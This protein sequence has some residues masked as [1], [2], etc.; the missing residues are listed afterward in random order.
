MHDTDDA[1]D[2]AVWERLKKISAGRCARLSYL[3]HDGKR[4]YKEDI[5]LHDRL[6]ASGHMS[7]TE[8]LARP[9]TRDEFDHFGRYHLHLEPDGEGV[10][11]I[12]LT[13][14]EYS[15]V[16]A[17]KAFDIANSRYNGRAI[18]KT[19]FDAFCGNFNGWIQ[20]RKTIEN[21]FDALAEKQPE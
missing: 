21:E 17:S 10:A 18:R 2:P 16:T 12:P 7:P 5:A 15:L 3:T 8:H 14:A 1:K 9:M 4:D 6:V 13:T 20:Y 11:R 19:T